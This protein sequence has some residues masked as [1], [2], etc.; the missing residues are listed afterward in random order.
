METVELYVTYEG[1][2]IICC[3]ILVLILKRFLYELLL[4][5]NYFKLHFRIT[6][7]VVK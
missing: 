6:Y 3:C 2:I 4:S 7:V 5:Y 1:F